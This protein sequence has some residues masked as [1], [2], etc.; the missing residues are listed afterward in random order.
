MYR[1]TCAAVSGELVAVGG[2]GKLRSKTTAAVHKYNPT[3]ESWD[4]ISTYQR[5]AR[6]NCLVAVLPTNEMIV[7]G[8]ST[9][10]SWNDCTDKVEIADIIYDCDSSYV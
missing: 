2:R 1:S 9:K 3:T 5:T 10:Y 7:V 6:R 4:L 8:G